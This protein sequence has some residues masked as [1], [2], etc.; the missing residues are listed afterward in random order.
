MDTGPI[1][2]GGLQYVPQITAVPAGESA[3]AGALTIPAE[4]VS[5]GGVVN[6]GDTVI[7]SGSAV[8]TLL[9]G[10]AMQVVS[11]GAVTSAAVCG[12]GSLTISSGGLAVNTVL[13]GGKMSISGGRGTATTIAN[14]SM[15]LRSG[16][17]AVNTVVSSGGLFNIFNCGSA[18][19]AAVF[20]GGNTYVYFGGMLTSVTVSSGGSLHLNKGSAGNTLVRSGGSLLINSGVASNTTV[21]SGGVLRLAS[22]GVCTG[23]MY[24]EAG[25]VVSAGTSSVIDFDISRRSYTDGYILNDFA[26]ISG[27]PAFTVTVDEN[28]LEGAYKLAQNAAAFTGIMYVDNGSG[29]RGSVLATGSEFFFYDTYY[30]LSKANG[31]LILTTRKPGV[32]LTG[33]AGKVSWSGVVDANIRVEYSRDGFASV[34]AVRAGGNA[35]E[36]FGL[37]AGTYQ[38]RIIKPSGGVVTGS[39][40]VVSSSSS[41]PAAEKFAPAADNI[42]DLF[43]CRA[44]G[45]WGST[46]AAE[47]HGSLNG[48]NGRGEQVALTG[49]NRI[50]DIFA[51]ST[52]ANTL[53]L[54]DDANG[55]ALFLEDIFTALPTG[56][57]QQ[58]RLAD[59][60]EIRSG[61]GNDIIDLTSEKFALSGESMLISGGDGDDV[62]WSNECGS[63]I[64]G[65]RGD[66]RIVGGSGADIITGGAGNDSLHGGG[67][68]DIFC[69]G[70]DWGSDVVEQLAG[71]TITLCF[72]EGS[73]ANW[74]A[75]SLTYADGDCRVKVK[76]V[77]AAAVT[78]KFGEDPQLPAGVFA[79]ALYNRVFEDSGTGSGKLA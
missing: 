46:Y 38:W 49:K 48:S 20:S 73:D 17:V 79:E 63:T 68:A 22:G 59:I 43:F 67:G 45:V 36:N 51:G 32:I 35:V 18:V 13:S 69:F 8:N 9:S 55:D 39:N 14:G 50:A 27:A 62:I 53:V 64:F 42:S 56:M 5:S 47:H 52:D 40:I 61:Y 15:S 3:N 72:A 57:S 66:D 58:V 74:D 34:L 24:F 1:T 71:G 44:S 76:G 37:P 7:V 16:G 54:T 75:A 21:K 19:S 65:D 31:N 78:L 77:D 2:D 29:E 30:A 11:G 70:G 12:E 6:S 23:S 10:G 33:T 41:V 26:C 4:I 60:D 25:A 28:Q